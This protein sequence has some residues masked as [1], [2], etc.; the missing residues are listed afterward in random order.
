MG[1]LD[2]IT[3]MMDGGETELDD[4]RDQVEI[5]V[6]NII[7]S[8]KE[9]NKSVFDKDMFEDLD[10]NHGALF[11]KVIGS[12]TWWDLIKTEMKNRNIKV[13]V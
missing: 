2:E 3:R 11:A 1:I 6:V 12:Q 5:T 10:R 7:N 13:I 4:V 8:M 9:K